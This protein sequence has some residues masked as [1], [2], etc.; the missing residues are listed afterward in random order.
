MIGQ[1]IQF[2]KTLGYGKRITFTGMCYGHVKDRGGWKWLIKDIK[3]EG[4]LT[5]KKVKKI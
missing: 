5:A 3:V 4:E 1:I 2:K